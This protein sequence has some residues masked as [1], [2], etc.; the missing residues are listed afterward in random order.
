[1]DWLRFVVWVQVFSLAIAIAAA[2]ILVYNNLA[3]KTLV[4]AASAFLGAV[5]LFGVNLWTELHGGA[6]TRDRLSVEYV[7]DRAERFIRTWSYPH[8]ELFVGAERLLVET[9]ASHW[10][11]EHKNAAFDGDRGY[12]E[13]LTLDLALFSLVGLL[14]RREFDWQLRTVVFEGDVAG[15]YVQL[16]RISKHGE[17]REISAE[18]LTN[19]LKKAGNIF[20]EAPMSVIAGAVCLPPGGEMQVT[21]STLA[22]RTPICEVMFTIESSG[23]GSNTVPRS[24]G[25]IEL[26]KGGSEPRYES[27]VV[28]LETQIT[29]F[30]LRAHHREAEKQ[31]AWCQRVVDSARAWFSRA[32]PEPAQPRQ[33][34]I[35]PGPVAPSP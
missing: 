11:A 10:L 18:E 6:P 17:C 13:R 24:G 15:T 21:R 7:I 4:L 20:A 14:R 33:P 3:S 32:E 9:D 23:G 22:L 19:A 26:L 2:V 8:T 34:L 35:R 31:A 12:R 5:V 25:K 28:G 16:A 1:M 29:Y 27:R 30:N